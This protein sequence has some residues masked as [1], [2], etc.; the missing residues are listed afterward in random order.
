M[1]EYPNGLLFPT[2]GDL[3]NPGIKPVSLASPAFT[4]GFF[5]TSATIKYGKT[6]V[7]QKKIF[8]DRGKVAKMSLILCQ[9][10]WKV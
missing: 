2:P 8:K 6:V 10:T 7:C 1:Q 4:G 9:H 3:P 5:T